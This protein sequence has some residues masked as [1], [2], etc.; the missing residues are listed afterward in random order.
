MEK[1]QFDDIVRSLASSED[2][3]SVIKKLAGGALGGLVAINAFGS[4][5]DA[6]RRRRRP[7]AGGTTTTVA[8]T[9]PAPTTTTTALTCDPGRRCD[10]KTKNFCGDESVCK[11]TQVYGDSGNPK[12]FD[13]Y[14]RPVQTCRAR[15]SACKVGATA[16][17][18]WEC[19][20]TD[21]Y[22]KPLYPSGSDRGY[23]KPKF[24]CPS[25]PGKTCRYADDVGKSCG[26]PK[27]DS[28]R[29]KW[30]G[31]STKGFDVQGRAIF[32]DSK[33]YWSC[34]PNTGFKYEPRTA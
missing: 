13:Y 23:C 2:R 29:C 32:T 19:C 27:P 14:C 34:E 5:A 1:K 26:G 6:R 3:R 30:N 18:N 25:T 28:C 17:S 12:D 24:T 20:S 31:H 15:Y 7:R 11:C 10:I 9:T 16:G 8:P 4:E 21:D 33:G 22:C